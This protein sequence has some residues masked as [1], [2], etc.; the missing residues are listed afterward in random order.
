MPVSL[1]KRTSRAADSRTCAAEPGDDSTARSD[2]VWIESTTSTR[3][4]APRAARG[5]SRR[6]SRRAACSVVDAGRAGARAGRPARSD[7]SPVTYST[8]SVA[9]QRVG[10]LQQQRRLADARVAARAAPPSPRTSPPPSTR[11]SSPMPV[12]GAVS[13][14]S[15]TSITVLL[16]AR[17]ADR[18]AAPAALTHVAVTA[19]EGVPGLAVGALALPLRRARAAGAA[20][21]AGAGLGHGSRSADAGEGIQHAPDRPRMLTPTTIQGKSAANF[22]ASPCAESRRFVVLARHRSPRRGPGQSAARRRAQKLGV[23]RSSTSSA[24]VPWASS[25]A[26]STR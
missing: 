25:T 17:G 10:G 19:S 7:S 26:R 23:T 12:D 6:G 11:S 13:V 21:V 18:A 8:G 15:V 5:S 9:A 20:D 14:S 22:G 24:R 2:M 16:V 3:R 4:S 1:A